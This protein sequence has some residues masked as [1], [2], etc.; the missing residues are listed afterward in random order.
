MHVGAKGN[1]VGRTR[2]SDVLAH[3][4]GDAQ[5]YG[6]HAR[7]AKQNGDR[8]H[9]GRLLHD[10]RDDSADNQEDDNGEIA[11]HI[12][13]AKEVDNSLVVLQ[14]E[15]L[16]RVAKQN[17]AV[18]EKRYTKKKIAFVAVLARIN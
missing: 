3:H 7:R 6:Q 16:A 9:G 14:V 13:R 15:R 12:E 8:H 17:E 4:Q 11:V 5:V 2:C 1:E 10:E 18:K